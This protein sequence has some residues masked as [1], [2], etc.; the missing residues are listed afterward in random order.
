M[1]IG[2][3]AA[4]EIRHRVRFAPDD[5]IEDPEVEVL[6]DGADAEDVVVEPMTQSVALGFITRRQ[7]ASQARVK[8]S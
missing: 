1:R 4:A 2:E 5:V 3:A 6:E 8:S 7:A